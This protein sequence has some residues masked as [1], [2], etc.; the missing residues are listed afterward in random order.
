MVGVVC[1]EESEIC[2]Q[3]R[4]SVTPP[5]QWY[6]MVHAEGEGKSG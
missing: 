5:D 2:E 6:R 3:V 4:I 1:F